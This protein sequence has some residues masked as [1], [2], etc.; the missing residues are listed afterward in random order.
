[1][2]DHF[3]PMEHRIRQAQIAVAD[4]WDDTTVDQRL[5]ALAGWAADRFAN[6]VKRHRAMTIVVH[7]GL[8]AFGGAGFLATVLQVLAAMKG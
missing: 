8:P 1:M 2:A 4:H 5:Y 3:D 6:G 7:V